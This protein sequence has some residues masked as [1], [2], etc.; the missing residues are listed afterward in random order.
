MGLGGDYQGKRVGFLDHLILWGTS[1]FGTG[2]P[3]RFR[4]FFVH[5]WLALL[6]LGFLHYGRGGLGGGSSLLSPLGLH[7]KT[8][9][10][11]RT[12]YHRR[13]PGVVIWARTSGRV[14]GLAQR[15]I[16]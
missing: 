1:G 14:L 8:E 15:S 16:S 7:E 5:C 11:G 2:V 13:G 10:G 3:S 4:M 6:G 9:L 12:A